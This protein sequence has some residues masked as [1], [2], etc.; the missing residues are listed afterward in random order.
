LNFYVQLDQYIQRFKYALVRTNASN[1]I[2]LRACSI[3]E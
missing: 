1:R 2:R 3:F